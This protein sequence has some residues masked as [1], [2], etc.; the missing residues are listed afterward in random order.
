MDHGQRNSSRNRPGIAWSRALQGLRHLPAAILWTAA[1]LVAAVVVIFTFSFADE[2]MRQAM[3]QTMNE[4]LIGYTVHVP[5]AHFHLFGLAVTLEDLRLAQQR[6]TTTPVAVI[7]KLRAR[8]QWRELLAFRLVSDF[9]IRQPSIHLDLAH[10]RH[11]I[12]DSVALKDHGWQ[13][14]AQAIYPFKINVLKVIDGDVVYVDEDPSRPLHLAHVQLR[15]SN[16]R[17]IQS[18]KDEYPST[19]HAEGV[20][21]DRGHASI[22]GRADFL[23]AP[24]P[25]LQFAYTLK[26]VPL[27]ELTP[28]ASRASLTLKGGTLASNGT[29]ETGPSKKVVHVRDLTVNRLRADYRSTVEGAVAGV[30]REATKASAKETYALLMDSVNVVNSELGVMRPA[31]KHPY[32]L[33]LTD[34]S[35]HMTNYSNHFANGVGNATLRGRFMGTGR[36]A[37]NIRLRPAD[38]G[39]NFDFALAIDSTPLPALNEVLRDKAS[40]DVTK[41]TLRFYSEITVQDGRMNGYV[42]PILTGMRIYDP[43][44]D[45][46]DPVAN[47]LYELIV[48]GAAKLFENRRTHEVATR[49]TMSGP[50]GTTNAS[51]WEM[52]GNAFENAFVHAILPGFE[53]KSTTTANK[54]RTQR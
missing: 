52:I 17:N 49:A 41:G 15:A 34:A 31:R 26:D 16:I 32:R 37:A 30:T 20:V 18:K 42:K 24:S 6:D 39:P 9:E 38:R 23:A 40:L 33:F 29:V 48:S 27:D 45:K 43:H 35:F 54:G 4:R 25:A 1:I 19:I 51:A 46:N 36:T 8:L 53:R 7:P 10:L 5:K 12:S 2:P 11:E 22:D 13:R 50:V 44:Q 28:I 3:E 14:A 47:Q 21:F